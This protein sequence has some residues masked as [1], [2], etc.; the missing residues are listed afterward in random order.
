[1]PPELGKS[2][3]NVGAAIYG[4]QTA[5]GVLAAHL[6]NNLH[7]LPGR[8]GEIGRSGYVIPRS[9]SRPR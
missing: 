9:L 5:V 7:G 6:F 4:G 1:M 8:C 2:T 3:I